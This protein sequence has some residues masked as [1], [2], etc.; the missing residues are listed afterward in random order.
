M[1]NPAARKGNQ[2][3]EIPVTANF[4]ARGF[5]RAYRMRQQG[6]VDKGDIGGIDDV[7]IE[8]KN[9]GIYKFGPWMKELAIEKINKS[10]RIGA[11]IVHPKGIGLTRVD[12]WWVVMSVGDFQ[13]L[14]VEAG[15]GPYEDPTEEH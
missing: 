5:I 10:A 3:G 1:S 6:A 4:V 13:R 9:H 15:Y 8:V 11:L 14:L 12:Q 2:Q 7:C